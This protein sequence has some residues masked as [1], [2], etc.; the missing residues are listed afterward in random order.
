MNSVAEAKRLTISQ[1][2]FTYHVPVATLRY[3]LDK[4]DLT[5][6]RGDDGR[7]YVDVAQLE[8]KLEDREKRR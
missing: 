2:S 8:Q 7:I 5:R 6:H 4:G 3:W 1:A